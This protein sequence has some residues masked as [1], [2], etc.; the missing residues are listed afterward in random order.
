MRTE[1]ELAHLTHGAEDRD[2]NEQQ[3]VSER[4]P[5]VPQRRPLSRRGFGFG[6][7]FSLVLC[8]DERCRYQ[9]GYTMVPLRQW[10]EHSVLH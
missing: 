5:E 3:R 7:C 1:H 6:T 8:W 10:N 4:G 9:Y 2:D